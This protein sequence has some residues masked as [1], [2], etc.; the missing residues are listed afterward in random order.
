MREITLP[1]PTEEELF[2]YNKSK[3]FNRLLLEMNLSQ[4]LKV[5]HYILSD[6]ISDNYDSIYL[7]EKELKF[8]R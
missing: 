6:W 5:N 4:V 8:K 1:Y 7:Y 3:Y 2:P